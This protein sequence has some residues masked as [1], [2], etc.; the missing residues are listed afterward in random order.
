MKAFEAGFSRVLEFFA[1][2]T[3]VVLAGMIVLICVDVFYRSVLNSGIEGSVELTEYALYLMML[4]TAPWLLNRGQHIRID[5]LVAAAPRRVAFAMEL[6]CDLIG[7]AVMAALVWYGLK[8]TLAS[9]NSGALIWKSFVFPEW[10][11]LAPLPICFAI[12]T[13]EFAL[14]AVRLCTGARRPGATTA[15]IG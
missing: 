4:L 14:R 8:N 10:W 15:A 2:I 1:M 5:F 9:Y 6:A 3:V 12:M 7:V 13:V 11:L